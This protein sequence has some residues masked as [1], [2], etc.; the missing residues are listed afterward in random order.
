VVYFLQVFPPKP[1]CTSPLP[2]TCYMLRP[3]HYSRVDHRNNIGWAV[4][5]LIM[6]FSPLPYFLAS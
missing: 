5:L 1:V 2:H 4:Q 3:S 6:K